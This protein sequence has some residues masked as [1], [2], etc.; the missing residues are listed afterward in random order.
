MVKARFR[1]VHNGG[2]G[3]YSHPDVLDGYIYRDT[4]I[5]L[6]SPNVTKVVYWWSLISRL[7][8]VVIMSR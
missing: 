5:L 8:F 6:V 3:S 4:S 1:D 7:V 2:V